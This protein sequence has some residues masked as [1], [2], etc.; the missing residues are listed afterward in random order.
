MNRRI[1]GLVAA[2]A[3]LAC[4]GCAGSRIAPVTPGAPADERELSRALS[5]FNGPEEPGRA[6]GRLGLPD[7]GRADFAARFVPGGGFRLDV[8]AGPWAKLLFTA[9]CEALGE[10]E[11]YFPDQA[12]LARQPEEGM[13]AWLGPL[14]VGRIP[15]LGPPAG[16]WAAPDGEKVLRLENASG[17]WELV[18]FDASGQRPRRVLFGDP[19]EAAA[20]ELVDLEFRREGDTW[21]PVALRI[22]GA[23]R[24]QTLEVAYE[25]VLRGGDPGATRFL[26]AAP[27]GARVVTERGSVAWKSMGLFWTPQP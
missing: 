18:V 24:G 22:N 6:L 25:R 15:L 26:G 11:A 9:A 4:L 1:L 10:C 27:P 16:A 13:S 12:L 5:R 17:R 19:G 14:L 20:L 23:G 3:A 2:L 8:T 7:G 21:Y